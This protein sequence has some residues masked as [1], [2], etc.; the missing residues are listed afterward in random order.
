MNLCLTEKLGLLGYNENYNVYHNLFAVCDFFSEEHD[1][2]IFERLKHRYMSTCRRCGVVRPIYFF[3]N[4]RTVCRPSL[5]GN[6]RKLYGRHPCTTEII[7]VL[8]AK[9]FPKTIPHCEHL[10]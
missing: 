5:C 1:D 9:L 6:C 10:N 3:I 4:Q 7:I 8:D 2:D